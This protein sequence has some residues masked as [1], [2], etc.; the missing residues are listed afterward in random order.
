MSSLCVVL[1]KIEEID[2]AG[3]LIPACQ[4]L[5]TAWSFDFRYLPRERGR[6]LQREL[7]EIETSKR[8]PLLEEESDANRQCV[9]MEF[10]LQVI[11]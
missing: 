11:R 4:F 7:E 10:A 3:I 9:Q 2:A 8:K 6:K 5:E 1:A